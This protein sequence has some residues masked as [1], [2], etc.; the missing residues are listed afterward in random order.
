MS[1]SRVLLSTILIALGLILARS[2]NAQDRGTHVVESGF[3]FTL[4][5]PEGELSE[6][7]TDQ[8]F[9][10]HAFIVDDEVWSALCYSGQ[11]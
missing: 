10:F 1:V 7:L 5:T 4:G 2:T 3:L 8:V 11:S 9:G 6:Y